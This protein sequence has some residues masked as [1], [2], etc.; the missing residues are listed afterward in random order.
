MNDQEHELARKIV[1]QLND[2][3]EQLPAAAR[4]RLEA[5]RKLA[6][7][8]YRAEPV[9]AGALASAGGTW[10]RFTGE[11]P[12]ALRYVLGV[13]T[14]AAALIGVMYLQ[15]KSAPV[16]ELTEIDTKILTDELPLNAYL[17][18]GFDSWL[19]RSSR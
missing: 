6:L 19:K 4:G 12:A 2:G 9:A 3:V 16:N 10:A 1:G 14:L 18:K 17:D 8:R 13:A 11:H 15:G 7:S 5:A